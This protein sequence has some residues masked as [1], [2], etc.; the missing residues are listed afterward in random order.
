[1]TFPFWIHAVAVSPG[2][3]GAKTIAGALLGGWI[4][5]E[6]QKRRAGIGEPTGD[7]FAVPLAIG[8]AIG[9]YNLFYR[10]DLEQRRLD[11]LRALSGSTRFAPAPVPLVPRSPA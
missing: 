6:I 8:I 2:I 11:P 3:I 1:V 9:R 10:D 4:A 7:L 5:V